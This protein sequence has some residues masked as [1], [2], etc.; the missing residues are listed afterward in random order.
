[1]CEFRETSRL[2]SKKLDG[3]LPFKKH[4]TSMLVLPSFQWYHIRLA[5]HLGMFAKMAIC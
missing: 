1:M 5:A 3:V 4:F 2:H